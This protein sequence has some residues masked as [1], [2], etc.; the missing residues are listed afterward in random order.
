MMLEEKRI[1]Y[2]VSK[3]NMRCY[4]DK[5]AEF[6]AKVPAGLLPVIELDGRVVTESAEIMRVLEDQ[7]PDRPLTPEPGT[8]DFKSASLSLVCIMSE[9]ATVSHLISRRISSTLCTCW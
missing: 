6:L 9:N 1:P 3:I 7:F 4:G 8:T 5:P 2:T